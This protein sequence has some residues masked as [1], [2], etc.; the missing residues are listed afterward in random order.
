MAVLVYC[1]LLAEAHPPR[2]QSGVGGKLVQEIEHEG[3]RYW[4]SEIGAEEL[5]Q[6]DRRNE[7]LVFHRVV[8]AAFA[9]TATIP[10]AFAQTMDS[11]EDV[12]ELQRKT[13]FRR[14]LQRL[15]EV[16]QMEARIVPANA[17]ATETTGTGY[18]R[19]R[20]AAL[21]AVAA[22]AETARQATAEVSRE[23]R[24]KGTRTGIRC[25]ALVPRQAIEGFRDRLRHAD[26]QGD[27]VVR[28]SGP[29]PPSEFLNLPNLAP[30]D[31]V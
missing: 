19:A 6:S 14:E 29:W 22:A 21:H 30:G 15:R 1:V 10:F 11:I 25:F 7:A 23:W 3:V 8:E 4:Y 31:K 5:A 18:L 20:Q 27:V 16:V 17:P 24:Q 2:P 13:D 9:Q 28:V 26:F 12:V